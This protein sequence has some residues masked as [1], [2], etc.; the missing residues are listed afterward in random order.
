MMSS[1]DVGEGGF[2]AWKKF[3][4]NKRWQSFYS[5]LLTKEDLRFGWGSIFFTRDDGFLHTHACVP[6]R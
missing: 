4:T 2:D 1:V 3:V 6:I 5:R